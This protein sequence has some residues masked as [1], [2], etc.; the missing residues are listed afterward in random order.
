MKWRS[1]VGMDL[2]YYY[3]DAMLFLGGGVL[4]EDRLVISSLTQL[5]SVGQMYAERCREQKEKTH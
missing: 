4:N 3:W 1:G 2:E 5:P